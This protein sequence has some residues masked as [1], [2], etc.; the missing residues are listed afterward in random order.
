[1]IIHTFALDQFDRLLQEFARSEGFWTL[2]GFMTDLY[3]KTGKFFEV[4]D[5]EG[6]VDGL[7]AWFNSEEELIEFKL[8]W[9]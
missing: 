9:L 4:I 8:R 6:I 5:T 3:E 1:M 7:E 2:N